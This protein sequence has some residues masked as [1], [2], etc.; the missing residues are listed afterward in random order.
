M[1]SDE[2]FY[3]QHYICISSS[4]RKILLEHV[5]QF[6]LFF[7]GVLYFTIRNIAN[8]SFVVLKIIIFEGPFVHLVAYERRALL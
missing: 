3:I 7:E 1:I 4:N 6:A 2:E 8:T 5:N